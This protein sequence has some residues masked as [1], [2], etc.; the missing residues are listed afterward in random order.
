MKIAPLA[1]LVAATALLVSGCSSDTTAPPADEV[2]APQLSEFSQELHDLLPAEVLERGSISFVG[3]PNAPWRVVEADGS[4]SGFQTD[5]FVEF[6]SILGIEI[7]TEQVT[8]LPAVKLGVQSGRNDAAFGPILDTPD[9]EK[10]LSIIV[11]STARPTFL[12]AKGADISSIADLCGATVAYLDGSA[13]TERALATVDEGCAAAKKDATVRLPLSDANQ[14]IMAVDSARADFASMG[15]AAAAYAITQQP[16]KYGMYVSSPDEFKT[17][18]VGMAVAVGND[19][20]RDALLGAWKIT[21]ENGVYGELM[22][23]YNL[24]DVAV[25][26]ILLNPATTL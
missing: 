20:L 9:A 3:D 13:A 19:G 23:K 10:D 4:V 25:E 12:H 8:G 26:E 17:D 14:T 16:G 11:Y 7:E 6:E 21:V 15:A 1:A 5:L 2:D 24:Q 18:Y 22:K